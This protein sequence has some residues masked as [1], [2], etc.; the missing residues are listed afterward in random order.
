MMIGLNA[1]E[2]RLAVQPIHQ[3]I[4]PNC[5][6][7][8]TNSNRTANHCIIMLIQKKGNA[9]HLIPSY[10]IDERRKCMV[11]DMAARTWRILI[12]MELMKKTTSNSQWRKER[13]GNVRIRYRFGSPVNSF[14]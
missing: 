2:T 3:T 11:D 5:M 6:K 4:T 1:Q 14:R 7:T 8:I 9:V 10:G 13:V 12:P